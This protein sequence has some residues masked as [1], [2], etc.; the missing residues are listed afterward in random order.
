MLRE[1]VDFNLTGVWKTVSAAA[2]AMIEQGRGGAIVLTSSTQG[3][4][5]RGGN[6][7]GAFTGYCAAKHG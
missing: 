6:G 5:G 1:V 2:P 4:T 3:L 7:G